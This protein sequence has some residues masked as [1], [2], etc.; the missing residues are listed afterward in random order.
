MGIYRRFSARINQALASTGNTDSFFKLP[1]IELIFRVIRRW[2]TSYSRFSITVQA[3]QPCR[4]MASST[5]IIS[6]ARSSGESYPALEYVDAV[7]VHGMNIWNFE[8]MA[9]L[10]SH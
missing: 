9:Y 1:A 3:C 7:S 4:E 10:L 6:A 5:S 2:V 8:E